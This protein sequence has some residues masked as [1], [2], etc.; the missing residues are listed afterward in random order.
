MNIRR[1]DFAVPIGLLIG[2]IAIGGSALLEGIKLKFLWQPTAVLVV[3]GGTTGACIIRRGVSGVVDAVRASMKLLVRENTD[4]LEITIARLTWLARRTRQEGV[5]VLEAEAQTSRDPLVARAL[6]LGAG[7]ADASVVRTTLDRMLDH[8]DEWGQRDAAT[9]EAA[10]G[11]APTFG[12]LGAVLGLIA[13]LRLLA[14][15]TTLGSGIATAF[16]ATLYGVGSA[17]L[18]FFP[19]AAR[20]REQHRLRMKQREALAEALIALAAHEVP[21]AIAAAAQ[22]TAYDLT[23]PAA[24]AAPAAPRSATRS[25]SAAAATLT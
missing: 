12:I 22:E 16:V 4:E 20:L 8:E 7:Y 23:N 19:L 9:F 6:M 14:D 15:P 21:S 13:V 11:Y 1:I 17:N 2:L 18:I 3:F 24:K 25:R 10:G 5:R